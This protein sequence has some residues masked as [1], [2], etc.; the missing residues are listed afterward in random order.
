MG[1]TLNTSICRSSSPLKFTAS[2]ITLR[3]TQPI[4][5]SKLCPESKA[6]VF[7]STDKRI[8]CA[9]ACPLSKDQKGWL[10]AGRFA[11]GCASLNQ[12]ST[13][14]NLKPMFLNV[15][16]K[17]ITGAR[18]PD[19]QLGIW[20][21]AEFEKRRHEGYPMEMPIIAIAVLEDYWQMYIA[22][23]EPKPEYKA[24]KGEKAYEVRFLG[25]TSIGSTIT[26]QDTFRLL[27]ILCAVMKWGLEVYKPWV[28]KD[29]VGKYRLGV[30]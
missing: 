2:L 12:T 20:I 29:I 14:T 24:T 11:T 9:I 8:D 4:S 27:H 18:D 25:P 5:P 19:V 3:S 1:V 17:T 16:V 28:D 13:W 23:A 21:G 26:V 22:Y 6:D 7:T 30:V 15:E 10:N